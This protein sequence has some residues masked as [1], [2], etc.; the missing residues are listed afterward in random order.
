MSGFWCLTLCSASCLSC[1]LPR[2][3]QCALWTSGKVRRYGLACRSTAGTDMFET[4]PER[5][6]QTEQTMLLLWKKY[7]S[8]YKIKKQPLI[9]L[10]VFFLQ[11]QQGIKNTP[12]FS[13][14]WMNIWVS[15]EA[16]EEERRPLYREWVGRPCVCQYAVWASG[17]AKWTVM[18]TS[19]QKTKRLARTGWYCF[20]GVQL[21]KKKKYRQKAPPPFPHIFTCPSVQRLNLQNKSAQNGLS[22]SSSVI[23][24][25]KKREKK[26]NPLMFESYIRC[27]CCSNR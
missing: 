27:L 15:G 13:N 24:Q 22:R 12:Y 16:E 17:G 3:G 25:K 18:E 4:Y 1:F 21:K 26:I 7:S 23:D 11:Q 9:T 19:R 2:S 5:L 20:F 6:G 10:F 14:G 8:N